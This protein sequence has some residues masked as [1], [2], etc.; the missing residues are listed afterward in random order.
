MLLPF[1]SSAHLELHSILCTLSF[2]VISSEILISKLISSLFVHLL[3]GLEIV[4]MHLSLQHCFRSFSSFCWF[5]PF[6]FCIV[7]AKF[8]VISTYVIFSFSFHKFSSSVSQEF[9]S[10]FQEFCYTKLVK[11]EIYKSAFAPLRSI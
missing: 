4:T 8:S 7:V 6:E 3:L 10:G 1:L 9:F 5:C 11:Q 2:V